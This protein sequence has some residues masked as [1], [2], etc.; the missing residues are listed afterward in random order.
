MKGVFEKETV[1]TLSAEQV[2]FYR[3]LWARLKIEV[4]VSSEVDKKKVEDRVSELTRDLETP[5][6]VLL[7]EADIQRRIA[8]EYENIG[9]I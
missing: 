6:W 5:P 8:K 1:R 2:E 3:R 9:E 4:F 7:N